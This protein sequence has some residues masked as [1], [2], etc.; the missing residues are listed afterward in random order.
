MTVIKSS[1]FLLLSVLTLLLALGGN[2]CSPKAE[3]HQQ[4]ADK[5]YAAQQYDWA[6]IEYLNVLRKDSKNSAAYARLGLIYFAE[7]RF[8]RAAFFLGN[9]SLMDTNNLEL[10]V[11][12][13]FIYSAAGQYVEA[14]DI[15]NY[16]MD[17][18]PQDDD[19]PMLLA[20]TA[21]LPDEIAAVRKRLQN[22][23]A[24]SDRVTYQV[25]LANLAFRE[26]DLSAA[27]DAAK[28]A[29]ILDPKSSVANST[30]ASWY[31]AQKDL[32][33]AEKYFKAAAETAPMR[34]PQRM[35]FARF[36]I[37]T[38]DAAGGRQ[39]LEEMVKQAPDYVPGILALAQVAASE[40][41]FDE[42]AGWLDKVLMQDTDNY[43]AMLF[44]C[45]LKLAQSQPGLAVTNLEKMAKVYPKSPLVQYQMAVANYALNDFT[46]SLNCAARAVA[47]NPNFT[48][49]V[50][51]MAQLQIKSQ[52]PSPAIAALEAQLQKQP[53]Q[54]QAKLL[55]ADAYRMQGRVGDAL[56]LYEPLEKSMPQNAQIPMLMGSAYVQLTNAVG[57]R[58]AFNRVLELEPDNLSALEQLVDLDLADK[59]F[60][61]ARQ[62]LQAVMD[63]PVTVGKISRPV[64]LQLLQA[65]VFLTAGDNE[66]SEVALQKA[67]ALAPERQ[68]ARLLLAQLYHD[69]GKYSQALA[70]LDAALAKDPQNLSALM[71]TAL[72]YN[73][74]KNYTNTAAIYEKVLQ[75]NPGFSA[76]LNNLA[77]LYSEFLNRLDRAYDLALH[78]RELL[79]Y[80]PSAADT[81]GWICFKRGTYITALNLL[82]E[83]A[84]LLTTEPEVQYHL[85]MTCYM[86]GDEAGAQT[87]LQ[88]ALHTGKPFSGR[89]ECQS[90]LS[91]LAINPATAD[92]SVLTLLEKRVVEKTDDLAALNRLAI[93]YQRAG[94]SNKAIVANEAILKINPQNLDI[95]LNLARLYAPTNAQRAYEIAKTAYK[96]APDNND[97]CRLYGNLAGRVGDY[98]LAANLLQQVAQS[99]SDSAPVLFDFAQAAVRI[100]LISDAKTALQSA[101][102]LNLPASQA[103]AAR[104]ML[105][106]MQLADN[107]TLALAAS[108]RVAEYLKAKPDDV[109][110]LTVSSVISA[111]QGET[112][113]A[114]TIAEKILASYPDF[115]PAQRQLVLLY[116]ADPDKAKT[117]RLY[118]FANKTR[119]I[120]PDDA[121][122]TKA[123][124]I[125]LLQRS[126]YGRAASQLKSIADTMTN[127]AE[128][129]YYLG[130]AQYRL[131]KRTESKANLQQSLDLNLTGDRV[132][133][134]KQMLN[135]LK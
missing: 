6:E 12:L 49:A 51:L 87:A 63:N 104:Q 1:S 54:V 119:G 4:M 112:T 74:Q 66:Q 131:N 35:Q 29:Q 31:W 13:G 18:K 38:G 24:N 123:F 109:L 73:E 127:D 69:T 62:R 64:E 3:K 16:V 99:Q 46:K 97:L 8:R 26:H 84:A 82:R 134:A 33:S 115:I 2:G 121:A 32:P 133:T 118:S 41:K 9:G 56:A 111:A 44:S 43:E 117:D 98:K 125:I 57:A 72:I 100:G 110:A 37:Q 92:A 30:L 102:T 65:K 103:E 105:E 86:T 42:A 11:K 90:A 107:P 52:N 128:W 45:Q 89:D 20:E 88:A 58:K 75:I 106:W 79:P 114:A 27:G 83:S 55:L 21:V 80:D 67:I 120:Y 39:M 47:L 126:E 71:L 17:R 28:R 122:L 95:L 53:Q 70:Q 68:G 124:G 78:A 34:S 59:Q 22:L 135:D 113:T 25:A 61:A 10:R 76:A 94:N 7:G 19:A 77:Y 130:T 36:K 60:G 23:A 96:L 108:A 15:A 101:L 14:R 50:L 48:E 81:L 129:F 91:I 93:I 40:K 5:F 85:G 132:D 116:A